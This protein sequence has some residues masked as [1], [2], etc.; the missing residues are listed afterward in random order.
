M[1]LAERRDTKTA[2]LIGT[3]LATIRATMKASK[4]V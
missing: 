2:V 1:R 4:W 3:R